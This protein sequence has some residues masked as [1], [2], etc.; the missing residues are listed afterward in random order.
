MDA[1]IFADRI[2][3]LLSAGEQ[4]SSTIELINK[5]IFHALR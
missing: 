5:I 3:F 4:F 1:V 2:A